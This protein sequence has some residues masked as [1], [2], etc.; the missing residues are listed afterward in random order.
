VKACLGHNQA[1]SK[2]FEPMI[3]HILKEKWHK[4]DGICVISAQREAFPPLFFPEPP[5]GSGGYQTFRHIPVRLKLTFCRNRKNN[6]FLI[7]GN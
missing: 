4:I 7:A 3:T 6:F 5:A 2:A 1:F